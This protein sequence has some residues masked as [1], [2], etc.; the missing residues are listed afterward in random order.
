MQCT[1]VFYHA[2]GASQIFHHLLSREIASLFYVDIIGFGVSGYP[3]EPLL[4]AHGPGGDS[5][6]RHVTQVLS[7]TSPHPRV[8]PAQ[9]NID[10][11]TLSRLPLRDY[12]FDSK[13]LFRS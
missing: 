11:I 10:V 3:A 13:K 4:D 5:Y 9:K 12:W 6:G 7:S 8:C 2:V 1:H